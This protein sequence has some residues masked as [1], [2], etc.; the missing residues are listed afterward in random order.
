MIVS[1]S[2]VLKPKRFVYL[3]KSEITYNFT[4]GTASYSQLIKDI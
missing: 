2:I 1:E 4:L 3:V